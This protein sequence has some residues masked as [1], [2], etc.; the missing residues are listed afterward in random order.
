MFNKTLWN[1]KLSSVA[2]CLR[3]WPQLQQTHF[4]FLWSSAWK[5]KLNQ[6]MFDLQQL[7]DNMLQLFKEDKLQSL[8]WTGSLKETKKRTKLRKNSGW[9]SQ[10]Q[11]TVRNLIYVKSAVRTV[12]GTKAFTLWSLRDMSSVSWHP[13][14]LCHREPRVSQPLF[15]TGWRLTCLQTSEGEGRRS[16]WNWFLICWLLLVSNYCWCY[17]S[18]E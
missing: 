17:K 16:V 1:L 18:E 11:L 7:D 2:W 12:R 5:L 8:L 14:G 10:H 15:R 4:C 3:H 9:L 6:T 13:T